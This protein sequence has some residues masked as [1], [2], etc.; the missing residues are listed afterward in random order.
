ME[1]IPAIDVIDGKCVRLAQGDYARKT[2][3]HNDPLEMALAF[4][5]AG[6]RRLHLV[7]L[8]GAKAGRIMN[9]AVLEKIASNTGLIIDFGGGIKT[10]DD[11]RSV[12]DAG[13]H[14]A[15]A[16]S[17]AVKNKDLFYSWIRRYG[18]HKILP[19]ADVKDGYITIGGWQERTALTLSDFIRETM[20]Q[21]I[22]RLFCTDV[23]KDG[24][25]QGPS[26]KLYQEVLD[27]FPEL[28][29][30]ASGGVS[31]VDD[32]RR[33]R[34][35]GCQGAIVGKALYENR[36]SMNDITTFISYA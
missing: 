25:L 35:I 22:R 28:E 31:S 16:G 23:S 13:A 5:Q 11:L 19:A 12:F 21:G 10:D 2:L 9:Q 4:E 8:D 1:I 7:D 6:I 34:D 14:M 20:Q 3:Y 15:V 17:I 27:D 32:L 36:I 24:L 26:L 33:L 29:L 30:I 18:P